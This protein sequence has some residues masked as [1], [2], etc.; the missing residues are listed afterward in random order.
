MGE[1]YEVLGEAL[2]VDIFVREKMAL[3]LHLSGVVCII[4]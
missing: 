2:A 4:C 1:P 3:S